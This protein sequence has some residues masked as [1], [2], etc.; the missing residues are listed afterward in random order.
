MTKRVDSVIAEVHE[1]HRQYFEEGIG[2]RDAL[3]VAH[4]RQCHVCLAAQI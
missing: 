2:R 1:I 4:V 3:I